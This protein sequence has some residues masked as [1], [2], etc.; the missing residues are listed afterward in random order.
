MFTGVV[1]NGGMAS[2]FEISSLDVS[3]GQLVIAGPA[4]QDLE[5]L[6]QIPA[7]FARKLTD[8]RQNLELELHCSFDGDKVQLTKLVVAKGNDGIATRDLLQL[9]L[10]ALIQTVCHEVIPNSKYWLRATKSD[11]DRSPYSFLAQLYWF[12]H[13]S[14]GNPRQRLMELMDWDRSGAIYQMRM[15]NKHWPLPGVHAKKN[16]SHK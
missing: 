14:W 6:L 12:E 8:K 11:I 3:D 1:H 13:V 4:D 9:G 2:G 7:V 15:L 16:S 5:K 10:P